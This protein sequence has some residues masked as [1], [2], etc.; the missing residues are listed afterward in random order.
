MDIQ[1]SAEQ[2]EALKNGIP[3]LTAFDMVIAAELNQYDGQELVERVLAERSKRS[4]WPT[5]PQVGQK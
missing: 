3:D 4:H 1:L 5:P 2:R